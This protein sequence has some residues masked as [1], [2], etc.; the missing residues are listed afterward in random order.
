MKRLV[1]IV[2]FAVLLATPRAEAAFITGAIS[3]S[4]GGL[5]LPGAPTTS[6]VSGLTTFTQ[7]PP[8]AN[9]CTGA[10]T[11]VATNCDL[12]GGITAGTIN[13]GAPAGVIYTYGGYSFTLTN[14]NFITPVALTVNGV[15]LG[16][17]S[18]SFGIGGTVT[19]NGITPTVFLG[20][21]TAN[22]VCLGSSGP[23]TCL[24][25]ISG[26]WSASIVAT[27]QGTTVPEPA[28]MFLLGSGLV[29]VAAAARRR[30]AGK[31]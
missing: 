2:G 27:G 6:I 19:G 24:S 18:I 14:V 8:A 5:T 20:V 28:S 12:P 17:D 30:M 9:S 13:T 4:D 7:G 29:G 15:G 21:F 11:I 1:L 16:Q 25:N 3:F 23:A 31:K 10:F 22:G 26:S